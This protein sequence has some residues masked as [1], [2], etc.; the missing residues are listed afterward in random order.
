MAQSSSSTASGDDL[1]R[2]QRRRK[3]VLRAVAVLGVLLVLVMDSSWRMAAP[4]LLEWLQRG[5]F[6]LI[7]LCIFGRTWC[8]LYIGGNKKREL[9][10][11][12]PYSVVRNPLYVFT[13]IGAMGVGLVAGSIVLALLFGALALLIFNAIT[14]QEEAF[15]ASAFGESF[16]AYAARVPRF[17]PR[18]STWQDAEE[19][20]VRPKLVLRTFLDASLFLLAVP[21]LEL[22]EL[23]QRLGSL[24]VWL[25]LP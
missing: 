25:H 16:T 10:T 11:K 2:L 5:G 1:Q 20:V 24:P 14:R 17:W 8:T 6:L 4:K 15:M 7:L 23:L 3:N 22:K 9:V 21:L 12:G 18:F 19:L 13:F